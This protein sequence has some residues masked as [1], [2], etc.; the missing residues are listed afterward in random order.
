MLIMSIY[1]LFIK[2]N[3]GMITIR[4]NLFCHPK[5]SQNVTIKISKTW[6]NIIILVYT[7]KII[8]SK[9]YVPKCS[10]LKIL[11]FVPPNTKFK[12]FLVV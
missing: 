5:C 4:F 1:I 10:L 2:I 12:P 6:A 11:M 9:E 8:I 7:F 3:K